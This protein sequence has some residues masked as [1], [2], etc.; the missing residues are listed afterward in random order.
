PAHPAD[1]PGEWDASFIRTTYEC[2]AQDRVRRKVETFVRTGTPSNETIYDENER[3]VR[4]R[5]WSSD[6]EQTGELAFEH[7][8]DGTY[9][10]TTIGLKSGLPEG[11]E[12]WRPARGGD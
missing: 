6:H 10:K 9:L 8:A 7:Q 3:K 1:P 2:D 12:Q 5:I 4:Y 11:R